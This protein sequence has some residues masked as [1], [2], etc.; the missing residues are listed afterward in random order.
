MT[1][2]A[3]GNSPQLIVRGHN[4]QRWQA[5]RSAQPL[6]DT[7]ATRAIEQAAQAALAPHTLMQRAGLS[8][9]KLAMAL[10]PHADTFWIACGPG[11]NGGDGL[12]AAVHLKQ[13]GKS[14]VVTWLGAPGKAPADAAASRQRALE[15]GVTFVE[16]PPAKFDFCIDAL[17]G[18]GASHGATNPVP[19]RS[20]DGRM[21]AWIALINAS[22]APVLAVDLPTGLNADTGDASALCVRATATLSLLTLKPG[23]FTAQGR[24]ASGD[25]WFDALE[26]SQVP[27]AQYVQHV[28]SKREPSAWLA[29]APIAKTRDHASH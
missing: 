25:I 2:S 7:A 4:A 5:P 12:E 9:A 14:P 16:T 20:I 8:S 6:F 28:Q 15:A 24:D 11:N 29:G 27:H 1:A 17:L 10:A 13:W 22:P 21:A 3:T 19:G 18:I 23:L 26:G